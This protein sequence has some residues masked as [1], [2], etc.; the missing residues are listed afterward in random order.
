MLVLDTNH[1]RELALET[2]RGVRLKA[3]L[4]AAKKGSVIAI[5]TVEEVLKG[6]MAKLAAAR[7]TGAL[8]FAYQKLDDA[9]DFLASYVRL[10]W[11]AEAGARFQ[12]FCAAGIRI[13]TMD[14]RIACIAIEHDATLLT[15]NVVDFAKVPGLRFENWLD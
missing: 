7:E 1:L 3:R 8:A 13:G 2:E 11:D 15:R 14:L 5:P 10:P 12:R 6:R 9:L 4:A